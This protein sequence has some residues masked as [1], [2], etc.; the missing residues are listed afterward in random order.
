MTDDKEKISRY[1]AAAT[2]AA[3]SL[4]AAASPQ[5]VHEPLSDDKGCRLIVSEKTKAL[6]PKGLL[7]YAAQNCWAGPKTDILIIGQNDVLPKGS[8][9]LTA[10]TA[11][12]EHAQEQ[13]K[14]FV[15]NDIHSAM[16]SARDEKG[17]IIHRQIV[18][19]AEANSKQA[20]KYKFINVAKPQEEKRL[21]VTVVNPVDHI[22]D[23]LAGIGGLY[24][25]SVL[26]RRFHEEGA[27]HDR[28]S[29]RTMTLAHETDH[30]SHGHGTSIIEDGKL[31]REQMEVSV[32]D[33]M[34]HETE[35]DNGAQHKYESARKTGIAL[36][37][38]YPVL[39]HG[40]RSLGSY[41]S[42]NAAHDKVP[43]A[44]ATNIGM[45]KDYSSITP[46]EQLEGLRIFRQEL[47]RA[48]GEAVLNPDTGEVKKELL[49]M[50]DKPTVATLDFCQEEAQVE[51]DKAQDGEK[52]DS[53]AHAMGRCVASNFD[54][55]ALAVNGLI[56]MEAWDSPFKNNRVA[57]IFAADF[58]L[59]ASAYII[60]NHY[61]EHAANLYTK[62]QRDAIP[63]PARRYW[64]NVFSNKP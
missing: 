25:G 44:H 11:V 30:G 32:A 58:K 23:D 55:R 41:F 6:Y 35:A 20:L 31:R 5:V 24:L 49:D 21:F 50:Y 61:M 34:R 17:S 13:M 18:S 37:S 62:T 22:P 4:V 51:S 43:F 15:P 39:Y 2:L 7:E 38:V 42:G 53:Y 57:K 19:A 40:L 33:R 36:N 45:H 3:A 10:S 1:V 59:A 12:V 48:V 60:D 52:W 64:D 9:N 46:Q 16:Q 29:I 63:E 28:A 54:V 8:H 47:N 26:N 14:K 56:E 27:Y